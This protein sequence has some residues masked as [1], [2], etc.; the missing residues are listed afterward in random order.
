[1][2]YESHML[3]YVCR[4]ITLRGFCLGGALVHSCTNVHV[5]YLI[6]ALCVCLYVF[7]NEWLQGRRRCQA[8]VTQMHWTTIGESRKQRHIQHFLKI[9][10]LKG[11]STQLSCSRISCVFALDECSIISLYCC[12]IHIDTYSFTMALHQNSE[13]NHLYTSCPDSIWCLISK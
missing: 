12:M 3:M 5:K 7:L 8:I 1:M 4:Y 11:C 2:C 9:N 10:R 13:N 6:W